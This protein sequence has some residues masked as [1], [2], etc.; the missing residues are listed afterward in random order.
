MSDGLTALLNAVQDRAD[1]E[2]CFMQHKGV[3]PKRAPITLKGN[4]RLGNSGLTRLPPFLTVLGSFYLHDN[5]S[6]KS[7]PEGLTVFGD[8]VL[9]NTGVTDLPDDTQV[10]GETTLPDGSIHKT[11]ESAR[12]ALRMKAL[13]ES[14]H[15]NG[16]SPVS[17]LITPPSL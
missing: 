11:A 3:L 5:K 1:R 4:Q 15:R 12:S 9:T 13:R 2:H 14:V 8:L 6:L 7:L 17:S 10:W 16:H